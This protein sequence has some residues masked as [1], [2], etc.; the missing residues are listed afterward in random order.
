MGLMREHIVDQGEC[1]SSIARGYGLASWRT[2]YDDPANTGFRQ[3]HPNP[4]V[5]F[6]GESLMIPDWRPHQDD[7]P[8]NRR[9]RYSLT[10]EITQLRV[11]VTDRW[12][13]PVANADW[14]LEI[15]SLVR[16]GTTANDGLI[17]EEIPADA[18]EGRLEAVI[19]PSTGMRTSWTLALGALDPWRSDSGAQARLNNLGFPCGRIDGIV[20]RR[21]HAASKRF[22][23]AYGLV[24]DG[25]PGPITKRKLHE[26][27]GC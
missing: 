2:I 14:R 12:R 18:V 15:G 27:H 6:P 26:V 5:I 8:T 9:H 16:N 11:V 7:R 13:R 17:Q 3:A 4:N 21:T 1:L 10:T 20:G 24:P 22:Q 23:R 25:I 19:D